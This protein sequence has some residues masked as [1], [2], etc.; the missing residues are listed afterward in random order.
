MSIGGLQ[1][2][3]NSECLRRGCEPKFPA[4]TIIPVMDLNSE[5]AHYV[6]RFYGHLMTDAECRA[7]MHL[8][9]AMKASSGRS[10]I[11]AQKEA[12]LS[13]FHYK[14]LSSEDPE[15]LRLAADGYEA[16]E[17]HTA[18][19]ILQEYGV[20]VRFN[21]CPRCGELARTPTAKQCRHCRHDW[22]TA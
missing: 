19:R 8:F 5:A 22:H 10:D 11:G 6:I 12:Q 7:Q 13:P 1:A 4:S 17:R 16:F 3:V 14:F 18:A 9:A 21:R 2:H 15:V 20:R